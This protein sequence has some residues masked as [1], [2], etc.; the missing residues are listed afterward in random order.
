MNAHIRF[1]LDRMEASRLPMSSKEKTTLGIGAG[2]AVVGATALLLLNRNPPGCLPLPHRKKN[3]GPPPPTSGGRSWLMDLPTFNAILTNT[4]ATASLQGSTVYVGMSPGGPV[5]SVSGIAVIPIAHYFS[6]ASL[7]AGV[8]NLPSGWWVLF[9]PESWALTPASDQADP[10]TAAK[11]CWQAAHA[12]GHKIWQ[13]PASDL[14]MKLDPGAVNQFAAY[15]AL[16]WGAL[17]A[18]YA[19]GLSIQGQGLDANPAAWT[20][21]TLSQAKAALAAN[22]NVIVSSGISS[23]RGGTPADWVQCYNSAKGTIPCMWT[24]AEAGS[25]TPIVQFFSLLSGAPTST[26]LV[27]RSGTKLYLNGSPWTYNGLNYWPA[28]TDPNIASSFAAMGNGVNAIRFWCFQTYLKNGGAID[29]TAMDNLVAAAQTAGIKLLPTLANQWGTSAPPGNPANDSGSDKIL[30]WWQSGYQ[31]DIPSTWVMT[32]YDWV[33]AVVTRY[34]GHPAIACWILVNEGQ[35]VNADSTCNESLALSTMQAFATT[36]G[37]MVKSIDPGHLL[38]LGNSAGY[39]G[40]GLQYCGSSN[41]DYGTLGSN[42]YL[43]ILDYHDYN[44]TAPEQGGLVDA[45]K[46]AQTVGKAFVVNESGIQVPGQVATD[47]IRAGYFRAKFSAWAASGVCGGLVWNW[48]TPNNGFEVN[49]NDPL[50]SVM[51]TAGLGTVR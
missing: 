13:A 22:P 29:W 20:A 12:A 32:Y 50:L 40:S 36:V 21:F 33:K 34:A 51:G 47:A 42:T 23:S 49:P 43:D 10:V 17:F 2:A 25:Y 30:S 41:Y 1:G 39:V 16:N 4:S 46:L 24:N 6:S 44:D 28:L 48:V 31:T 18:P 7:I 5:P 9:D 27:I 45:L 14:A 37:Q 19:D 8:G 35:A 3:G 11:N 38:C 26:S 15:T